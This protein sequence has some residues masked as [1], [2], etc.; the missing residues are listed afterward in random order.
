MFVN[1]SPA[2]GKVLGYSLKQN[3][4]ILTVLHGPKDPP[5]AFT[6]H[7]HMIP[8]ETWAG[9]ELTTKGDIIIATVQAGVRSKE[10]DDRYMKM[11]AYS[12]PSDPET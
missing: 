8:N 6:S 12:V 5:T 1:V 4:S 7:I 11:C 2:K 3:Q 9:M 10:K